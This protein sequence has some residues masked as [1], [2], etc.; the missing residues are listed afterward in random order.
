MSDF[1]IQITGNGNIQFL[2]E[3]KNGSTVEGENISFS[4]Q[5]QNNGS[6]LATNYVTLLGNS[7]N[8]GTINAS[9][10]LESNP[11]NNLLG[12]IIASVKKILGLTPSGEKTTGAY[13]DIN[14]NKYHF[15]LNGVDQGVTGLGAYKDVEN[16]QK[17]Y[18]FYDNG[19]RHIRI[20]DGEAVPLNGDI[21]NFHFFWVGD[22]IGKANDGL[23]PLFNGLK[24][25]LLNERNINVAYFIDGKAQYGHFGY[26]CKSFYKIEN[27][28]YDGLKALWG[29][30][31]L[32]GDFTYHYNLVPN[33]QKSLY[34]NWLVETTRENEARWD[35]G[36][37]RYASIID[38]GIIDG[39]ERG[40][41]MVVGIDVSGAYPLNGD[42]YQLPNYNSWA[43]NNWYYFLHGKIFDKADNGVFALF[44]ISEI[45]SNQDIKYTLIQQGSCHHWHV[46]DRH[47]RGAYLVNGKYGD[48]YDNITFQGQLTSNNNKHGY[49][50][51]TYNGR[52]YTT[53]VEVMRD[54]INN[55][56]GT[57]LS[58]GSNLYCDFHNAFP[59]SGNTSNFHAFK[60]GEDKGVA[61]GGIYQV[62]MDIKSGPSYSSFYDYKNFAYFINGVPYNKQTNTPITPDSNKEIRA[63]IKKG[64]YLKSGV[65]NEFGIYG[66]FHSYLGERAYLGNAGFPYYIEN[67]NTGW[68]LALEGNEQ[69]YHYFY[70]GED[71]GVANGGAYIFEM[72]WDILKPK[73]IETNYNVFSNN[74]SEWPDLLDTTIYHYMSGGLDKGACNAG[75][76]L[77]NG[78][79]ATEEIG[80]LY[81]FFKDGLSLEIANERVY[82][83]NGIHSTQQNIFN[84]ILSGVDYGVAN[85]GAY[86]SQF[87][88]PYDYYNFYVGG[89]SLGIA[90][91]GAF[92]LNGNEQDYHVF[93]S[94][95]DNGKATGNYLINGNM[96]VVTLTGVF[97]N[98]ILM[99]TL[100]DNN[101]GGGDGGG[102]SGTQTYNLLITFTNTTSDSI[103][104]VL[105]TY[106]L[107]G[108]VTSYNYNNGAVMV[109]GSEYT[110]ADYTYSFHYYEPFD[111]NGPPSEYS[112]IKRTPTNGDANYWSVANQSWDGANAN[113]IIPVKDAN[114]NDLLIYV[115]TVQNG[116]NTY[117]FLYNSTNNFVTSDSV[118][119]YYLYITND[120]SYSIERILVSN[121]NV[122]HTWDVS[123]SS[124]I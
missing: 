81:E 71:E 24:N 98:G 96:N 100:D 70:N 49:Y 120:N 17:Y 94:G 12:S 6:V 69:D 63:P 91:G 26:G 92:R 59:L 33:N 2:G 53:D 75:A 84:Y 77:V 43:G 20:L 54:T 5:S 23:Y 99:S 36:F 27:S 68:V 31:K 87:N 16:D 86:K 47:L 122:S 38:T 9:T 34:K 111:F 57:S 72:G 1:P 42:Y 4:E 123:T 13:Y 82:I 79:H 15:W 28:Y 90:T 39:R 112:T 119:D 64:A 56:T 106:T 19:T 76:Y 50:L 108:S 8:T 73:F 78:D 103:T 105:G 65:H 35:N 48:F 3:T 40:A 101:S 29:A 60:K 61:N 116:V 104:A 109:N 62:E 107:N 67:K 102:D 89:S 22:D 30:Y 97:E 10:V 7:K 88:E 11:T 37:G 83:I 85:N 93:T 55:F 52:D 95:I 44:G 51:Q 115:G 32:W 25:N 124:W 117:Q 80:G 45:S 74:K 21:N 18:H 41:R 110:D 114:D 113:I 14:D 66:F 121:T 58:D 46:N 118:Y